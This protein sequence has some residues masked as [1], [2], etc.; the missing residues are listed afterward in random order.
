MHRIRAAVLLFCFVIPSGCEVWYAII[1]DPQVAAPAFSI[2]G[3]T[4]DTDQSITISSETAGAVIYYTTN[5]TTPTSSSSVYSAPISV[6]GHGTTITISAVAAKEG[7]ADSDVSTATYSVYDEEVGARYL[8][9][10]IMTVNVDTQAE[11]TAELVG[12]T[13]FRY[14]GAAGTYIC[15]VDFSQ[16]PIVSSVANYVGYRTQSG[17]YQVSGSLGG[18]VD[19]STVEISFPFKGTLDLSGGVI[20]TLSLDLSIEGTTE[21]GLWVAAT[22]SGSVTADGKVFDVTDWDL[23]NE[24]IANANALLPF[25]RDVMGW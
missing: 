25:A 15:E 16:S 19:N 2:P 23:G 21:D 4:Y 6:A 24:H 17:N 3:G 20:N 5:N 11:A 12:E 8:V 7:M 22:V 18:S 10:D 14:V 9:E 1:G 13:V